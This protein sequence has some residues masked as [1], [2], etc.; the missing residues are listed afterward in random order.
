MFWWRNKKIKFLLHS[1][2]KSCSNDSDENCHNKS[3]NGPSCWPHD[4]NKKNQG[5]LWVYGS[6]W[7]FSMISLVNKHMNRQKQYWFVK[8]KLRIN[9]NWKTYFNFN[10]PCLHSMFRQKAKG[11]DSFTVLG[12]WVMGLSW[13]QLRTNE[14]RT[15]FFMVNLRY[16]CLFVWLI[17]YV[18]VNNL[19]VMSRRVFQGWTST[20]QG[21]MCLAPGHNAVTPVRLKPMALRSQVKHS[22]T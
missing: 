10:T 1:Q 22:T 5:F 15:L 14:A 4:Y 3:L 9:C 11:H 19:S 20:K 17:L 12:P 6:K 8:Q 13:Y 18:P 16:H 7:K 2:L 21:L